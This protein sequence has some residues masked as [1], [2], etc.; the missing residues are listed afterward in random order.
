MSVRGLR[1]ATTVEADTPEQILAATRE[2][3]RAVLEQNA[4]QASDIAALFLTATADLHS[5]FPARAVRLEGDV[6]VPLLCA[7]ELDIEGALPRCIRLLALANLERPQNAVRHVYLR[8]A[9]VLRPD[10]VAR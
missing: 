3:Y 9:V 10:Q 2:L 8:G 5:A 6:L 7:Q 1:G 4:V